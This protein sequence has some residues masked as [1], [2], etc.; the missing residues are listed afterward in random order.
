MAL[1]HFSKR[2]VRLKDYQWLLLCW[3]LLLCIICTNCTIYSVFIAKDRADFAASLFWAL[4]EYGIWLVLTPLFCRT[5]QPVSLFNVSKGALLGFVY[6]PIALIFNVLLT[7]G[8]EQSVS[9]QEFL[10]FNWH[11]HTIAYIAIYLLWRFHAKANK[12]LP[13]PHQATNSETTQENIASVSPPTHEPDEARTTI[14][15]DG[16]L[17]EIDNI[18]YAQASGNYVDIFTNDGNVLVRATMKELQTLLP[19]DQFFRSHRSYLVNLT[20]CETVLNERAGH[21]LIR[22]RNGQSVPVSKSQRAQA[23][24]Y[25]TTY[26]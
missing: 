4:R 20:Y 2:L 3:S 7:L 1:T 5:I 21:G 22:L 26:P 19:S 16:R 12:A 17:I 23:H 14:T 10:F 13:C 6:I 9:W 11:K 8:S 18:H 25:V 24:Q 15:L